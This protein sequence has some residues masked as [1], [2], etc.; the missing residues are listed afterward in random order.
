MTTPNGKL[1]PATT[2]PGERE[3]LLRINDLRGEDMSSAVDGIELGPG[4][5]A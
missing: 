2:D 4:Q 1:A 3:V 5:I